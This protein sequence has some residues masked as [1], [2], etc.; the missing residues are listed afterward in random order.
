MIHA[1]LEADFFC[2]FCFFTIIRGNPSPAIKKALFQ[3]GDKTVLPST[4]VRL[5][6]GT[7]PRPKTGRDNITNDRNI[8]SNGEIVYAYSAAQGWYVRSYRTYLN[9]KVAFH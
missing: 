6:A 9:L 8:C 7:S 3:A 5:R 1:L 4:P 2:F